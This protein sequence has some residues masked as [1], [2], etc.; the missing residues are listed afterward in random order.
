MFFFQK[1][2]FFCTFG[3][4]AFTFI[5]NC[6]I[7]VHVSL[8][9]WQSLSLYMYIW[10]FKPLYIWSK[11]QKW[12][13][14]LNYRMIIPSSLNIFFSNGNKSKQIRKCYENWLK[15]HIIAY[16]TWKGP[17]NYYLCW[18]AFLKKKVYLL[19][20][21]F[22]LINKYILIS[23]IEQKCYLH[24]KAACVSNTKLSSYPIWLNEI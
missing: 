23:F 11:T 13:K 7:I 16:R 18:Y 15:W 4:Y 6:N 12:V 8:L 9:N 14:V 1:F 24:K 20:F 3:S 19:M 22:D 21:S 17:T 10:L 2:Y 5:Y